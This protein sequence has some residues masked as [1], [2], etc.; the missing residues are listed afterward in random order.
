MPKTLGVLTIGQSP[1]P[2]S[3]I[4]EIQ[5]VVGESIRVVE[6]GALDGLS[7]DEIRAMA[8][9]PGDYHL[10]TLL[11]DGASVQVN[12]AAILDRLQRQITDLEE[13]EDVGATLLMCTGAFPR[14]DHR[15][16]LLLPQA[17][18]YGATIG[19]ANGGAIGSLIPLPAQVEQARA[20][21]R[22]M[23]VAGAVVA[24]ANPYAADP[25]AEVQAGAAAARQ[26][27]ATILFMDCFGF[28]RAMRA[29]ARA[30]FGGPVILARSLAAR[31]AAEM[32]E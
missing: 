21:W 9:G 5:A 13:H 27:G 23:G 29:A 16:P 1:R 2:D 24:S 14:F 10:I 12:K 3:L 6:R 17:A 4:R 31:L 15:R 30:A 26:V 28:D 8:P 19:M 7:R 18:L 32:M 11:S 22:Q 20:K 25:L